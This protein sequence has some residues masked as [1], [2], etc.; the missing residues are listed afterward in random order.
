MPT[1][2]QTILS[3]MGEL[4]LEIIIS[5]MQREFN[6][7]VNVGKPQ[8]VYREAV[9]REAKGS[10]VFDRDVAGR[11]HFAEVALRII[12]MPR[13]TAAGLNPKFQMASFLKPISR[14]LKKA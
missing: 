2:G 13:E 5:R 4:H 9:S 14:K 8:V 10:A 3:G 11:R 7:R 12:P 6:T 1:T